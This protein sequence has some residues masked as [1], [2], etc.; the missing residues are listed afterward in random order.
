MA[1]KDRFH[2][3]VRKALEKESHIEQEQPSLSENIRQRLLRRTRF[4]VSFAGSRLF[5]SQQ[6]LEGLPTAAIPILIQ[7]V[8]RYLN[9]TTLAQLEATTP[10]AQETPLAALLAF[11]QLE[12]FVGQIKMHKI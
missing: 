3:A 1:A 8:F 7:D 11:F 4:Q 2:E 12:R 6:E 9:P 10:T 5:R